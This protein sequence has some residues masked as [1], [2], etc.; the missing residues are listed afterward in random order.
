MLFELERRMRGRS[1][2]ALTRVLWSKK[3]Q[4][5]SESRLGGLLR[6]SLAFLQASNT[7]T[8][9]ATKKCLGRTFDKAAVVGGLL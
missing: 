5:R 2:C 1:G 3:D 8:T 7:Q 6:K 9:V 4:D